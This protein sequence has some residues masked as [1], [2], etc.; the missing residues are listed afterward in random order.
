MKRHLSQ[1]IV[2]GLVIAGLA[3][4]SPASSATTASWTVERYYAKETS[5]SFADNGTK[6]GGGPGDIYVSRQTL[7]DPSGKQVGTVN[8][9]G[10]N[11][12]APYVYFHYT[13]VVGAST[14]TVEG[15]VSLKAGPQAFAIAGGTGRYAG[16]SGTVT[17]SDAGSKGSLVVVRY[18]R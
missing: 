4:A 15:G 6:D 8:G 14:L 18:R 1:L 3:A 10:I 16:T 9:Y 17:T 7:R 2:V 11:L 5:H 13:A 12:H